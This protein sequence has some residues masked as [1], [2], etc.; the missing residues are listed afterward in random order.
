MKTVSNYEIVNEKI[1]ISSSYCEDIVKTCRS[2]A[3]KFENGSWFVPISRLG[4][5]EERLGKD[6]SDLVE[7][8]VSYDDIEKDPQY[9]IGW[10]VLV[11]RRER[12][13]RADVYVDLI[14]GEIPSSGGSVKNPL[15]QASSD[16]IFRL[17]V[18]RDFALS[19]NLKIVNECKKLAQVNVNWKEE[20]LQRI[21]DLAKEQNITP[22]EVL[23]KAV[24][25]YLV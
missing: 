23:R 10:Y 2:W 24:A 11:N 12:D 6:F 4:Q 14:H 5:V 18:P 9:R 19:R 8:E 22:E 7:I 25:S 3:G 15:V 16:S 1:K 21:Y 20:E 13:R 17:W